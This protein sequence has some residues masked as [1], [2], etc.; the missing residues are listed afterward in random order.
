[1]L[2]NYR[3]NPKTERLEPAAASGNG[4]DV[5]TRFIV[6]RQGRIVFEGNQEDLEAS[7]DAYVSKFG[8]RW[9]K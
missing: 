3:Y 9:K 8:R 1:L 5:R 7:T 2:A 6:M 4:S